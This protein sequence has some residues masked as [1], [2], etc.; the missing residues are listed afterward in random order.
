MSNQRLSSESGS[1]RKKVRFKNG[2]SGYIE[3][4]SNGYQYLVDSGKRRVGSYDPIKNDT[5]D[6][7]GK[8]IGKGNLLEKLL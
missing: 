8:N 5:Y 6:K 7:N 2:G 3:I 1:E 4:G